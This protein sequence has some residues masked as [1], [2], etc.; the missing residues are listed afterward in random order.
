[1]KFARLLILL[2][3][4]SCTSEPPPAAPP[5]VKVS[6]VVLQ[7]QP[8]ALTT[9]LVGRT[10]PYLM[11]EVRPQ[12]TGIIKQRRFEEGSLVK[13]GEVLYEIEP[14]AFQSTVNEARAA[15]ANAQATVA[16]AKLRSERFADLVSIEAVAR[17]DADDATATYR[18]AVAS[19]AQQKA[20][21]ESAQI[22]LQ[23]TKITAPIS[24][25][26]GRSAVTPGALV[27][28]NQADALAVI[29]ALDPMYVD[30]NQSSAALLRLKRQLGSGQLDPGAT[31]VSLRLED[32]SIYMH[33]GQMKFSEVAVDQ[34][35]GSV[36]LR[37]TFPNPEEELLP[38]MY[39][40]SIV[41]EAM[42][43]RGL[44]VPQQGVM[45]DPKGGGVALVVDAENK[46]V[47]RNVVTSRAM[48]NQWLIAKGLSEGD[49]L[50][51]EGVEKTRAGAVVEPIDVSEQFAKRATTKESAPVI[52]GA[53]GS[54]PPKTPNAAGK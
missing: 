50:I 53:S 17:Q 11:S 40:Q 44:L 31:D 35:T 6:V 3:I 51:V 47:Q 18:Q 52:P 43:P 5:P 33:V 14:A 12:V 13:A 15:L 27:G 8:V 9:E 37:A 26:I 10:T 24:G 54:E 4:V 2:L 38:G 34:E 30:M 46:V 23:F 20:A 7:T 32:G 41:N 1:M 21:L 19:V 16:A 39:V 49:R 28:A 36:T 48:G 42:E 22:Q 45:R 29:R 25:R